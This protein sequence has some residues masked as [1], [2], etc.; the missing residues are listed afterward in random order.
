MTEPALNA[1]ATVSAQQDWLTL[2]SLDEIVFPE[3]RETDTDEYRERALRIVR[4]EN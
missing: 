2:E 4:S 1:L 3:G